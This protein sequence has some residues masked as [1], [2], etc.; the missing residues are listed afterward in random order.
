MSLFITQRGFDFL[1]HINDSLINDVIQNSVVL[2]KIALGN[3]KPNLY[4]EA[5][6]KDYASGTQ[7]YAI[8]E[9]TDQE[10]NQEGFGSDVGWEV[11][12]GFHRDTLEGYSVYPEMGDIIEWNDA[13]FEVDHVIENNIMGGV[14]EF[15]IGFLCETHMTRRS[16][17]QIEERFRGHIG[18]K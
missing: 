2:Y 9:T 3:T 4:G 8:I 10:I 7:L 1:N 6:D 14:V 16:R 11:K 5:P 15:K 17:L 12:F 18:N 13:Y